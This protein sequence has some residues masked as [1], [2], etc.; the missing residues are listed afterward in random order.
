LQELS[1]ILLACPSCG[2][3]L[4]HVEN[5]ADNLW[6][7]HPDPVQHT[8]RSLYL[9]RK[10]NVKLPM[11]VAFDTPDL[12]SSCGA[13][14]VSVH[15]LQALTMINSPFMFDQSR[16]LASRLFREVPANNR[17]RIVRLYELALGRRPSQQELRL[18]Q[19]F[20]VAQAA[21][22]KDRI[23]RDEKIALVEKTPTAIDKSTA[24]AWIDLCLATMNLN[25]FI[26]VR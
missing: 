6:P 18:T 3:D 5:E 12:M 24:A 17:L 10:R 7:V 4:K 25:E 1:N 26:Y 19:D 13:R 11:L 22:I 16:A 21:I 9:L 14:S 20:L 8:R 15:A 2:G 23:G